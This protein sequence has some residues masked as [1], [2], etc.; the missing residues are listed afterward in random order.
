MVLLWWWGLALAAW[1]QVASKSDSLPGPKR[2]FV[3]DA[4]NNRYLLTTYL[5]G[6]PQGLPVPYSPE[7]YLQYLTT[8]V[9]PIDSL[10]TRLVPDS[11]AHQTQAGGLN[12][13]P[14]HIDLNGY[15]EFAAALHDRRTDN[16]TLNEGD[17]QLRFFNFGQNINLAVS[18]S[19]G[20]RLTFGMNY[21]TDAPFEQDGRRFR[22]AYKGTE[23]EIVQSVELGRVNLMPR[24]SLINPGGGLMGVYGR[25]QL[26]KLRMDVVASRQQTMTKRFTA[27][28]GGQRFASF[29]L[30]SDRY[31]ARRHFFLDHFFRL[32]FD[33][34][35]Q[36]LPAVPGEVYITRVEVWVTNLRG[37]YEGARNMVAVDALGGASD[38]LQPPDNAAGGVY[39]TLSAN[40]ALRDIY[41]VA[42]VMEPAYRLHHTYEAV[43]SARLLGADEYT[44]QPHLGYLMLHRRLEPGDVLAVAYEY[45][46]RGRTYRVGEFSADRPGDT[47]KNLLLRLLKSSSASPADPTWPLMMKNVYAIAEGA[48]LSAN[49]FEL[50]I[51]AR[52]DAK[53]TYLPYFDVPGK[54]EQSILK[55]LG[56]DRLNSLQDPLPDGRYD[57][58]EGYTVNSHLGVVI[59]PWTEPFRRGVEA[60]LGSAAGP[61][62]YP[63]LYDD[64]PVAAA[65]QA[66]QNRYLLRGRYVPTPL[67]SNEASSGTIRQGSVV[68]RAAGVTLTE[69]VDYEVDYATGAVQVINPELKAS[70]VP[71]EVVMEDANSE[72]AQRRSVFGMDLNYALSDTWNV[73]ATWMHLGE[74]PLNPKMAFGY[75]S[76]QNT[77]WGVNLNWRKQST[78]LTE[79]LDAL[80]F[81]RATE[82]SR[83]SLD[84]EFAH[85]IPGH[86]KN[87]YTGDFSYIDDFEAARSYDD[88]LSAYSWSLGSAP[89]H[90]LA[91][92]QDGG[93]AD[94]DKASL[95]THRGLLAWFHIDPILTQPDQRAMPAYLRQQPALL[96]NPYSRAVEAMELFPHRNLSALGLNYL[97]TLNV[98]FYPAERGPYNLNTKEL[99]P[100]GALR[101]PERS[102]GAMMRPLSQ[103]DFEESNIE[104]VEFW[105][106]DPFIDRP[107]D[108]GGVLSIQLGDVSED[109]LSDGRKAFENGLPLNDADETRTAETM[110][111][112]VPTIQPLTFGFDNTSGAL[113]KQDVGLNGLNSEAE[114]RFGTYARYLQ[115]YAQVA[116]QVSKG[117]PEALG[118]PY[119]DPAGDDYVSFM[120]SRYDRLKSPVLDRYKYINGSEGNSSSVWDQPNSYSRAARLLPDVEDINQDNNLNELEQYYD[121]RIDLKPQVL[122]PGNGFVVDSRQAMVKLA[123]GSL[124]PMTWYLFR[125]PIRAYDR[126]VG[127][128]TDFR[129][130][131]FMRIV[132]SQFRTPIQ[133]R[134]GSL[135]LVRGTWR[136]Y[137]LPLDPGRVDT[138]AE[139]SLGTV[140]IEENADRS[141]VNY[142]LPPGVHQP[143]DASGIQLARS[144]EQSLSLSL[145]HLAPAM[146]RGVYKNGQ[147]D[148][149]RYKRI[150]LYAHAE[151]LPADNTEVLDGDLELFVR[152]G[153]DYRQN[154]YEYALPLTLTPEG[155]YD[156]NNPLARERVWPIENLMR[157]PLDRLPQL[158]RQR[159][160]AMARGAASLMQLFVLPDGRSKGHTMGVMGQPSLSDVRALMIGVRNRSGR[161]LSAEVWVDEFRLADYDEDGGWAAR[162]NMGVQLSDVGMANMEVSHFSAGFG[163]LDQRLQERRLGDLTRYDFSTQLDLGRMMPPVLKMSAPLYVS[164]QHQQSTPQYSPLD[165][166]LL[167][168]DALD[169]ARGADR[170]SLLAL[171]QSVQTSTSIALTNVRMDIRSKKPMPYDPANVS[172]SYAHNTAHNRTPDMRFDNSR[173]WR[174]AVNYDYRPEAKPCY[175][176]A[177]WAG[178]DNAQKRA[179][180]RYQLNFW[181]SRIHL[182]SELRRF[183]QEQQMRDVTAYTAPAVTHLQRFFWNR[184]MDV[185]WDLTS[186]LRLEWQSGTEARIAEPYRR[187]NR[188]LDPDGYRIWRDSV[189]AS[190]RRLGEPLNYRQHLLV[191]YTLPTTLVPMLSWIKGDASWQASYNWDR[192]ALMP[193]GESL[194]GNVISNSGVANLRLS[195]DM[196]SC[197]RRW[198]SLDQTLR[199]VEE[200]DDGAMKLHWRDWL[201]YTAMMLRG[202]QLNV[203]EQHSSYIP[204]YAPQV[205][206]AGG[207]LKMPGGA[208][209]PGGRF[210]FGLTG[211]DF[212]ERA[213]DR[214][215]LLA[216][217]AVLSP[218]SLSQ[219]NTF[220]LLLRLRPL[221]ALDLTL[222]F[223]RTDTRRTDIQYALPQRPCNYG[224]FFSMTVVG[225][226]GF[227]AHRTPADGYAS[228][229]F[230]QFLQYRHTVADRWAARY[231]QQAYPNKGFLHGSPLAGSPIP[232]EGMTMSA[233]SAEVL[234]P[235]FRAAYLRGPGAGRIS[236]NP[237]PLFSAMMPNWHI[238]YT[239]LSRLPWVRKYV[240]RLELSTAYRGVYTIGNYSS[241]YGWAALDGESWVG[242]R[243]NEQHEPVPAMPYL[244]PTVSVQ[245]S[246]YPLIGLDVM[247]GGFS[248]GTHWRSSRGLLLNTGAAQL[249]ESF[250][251]EWAL[252][253]SYKLTALP[254]LDL[255]VLLGQPPSQ[256][257]K[258]GGLLLR[259]E[260]S[261]GYT[262][263]LIRN[264]VSTVAQATAGN[265]RNR[266][267]LTA[268]YDLSR[269]LTLRGYYEWN[270]N[271]PLVSSSSFPI[272]ERFYGISLRFNFLGH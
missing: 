55:M 173:D 184:E 243:P 224:G 214:G 62:L 110:W 190:I 10:S 198:T 4:T 61:Y 217:P 140:S 52:N 263:M 38:G 89:L 147:Y 33:K 236:L 226:R 7:Q 146:A 161:V 131:R 191:S 107:Q 37:R 117:T 142:V 240:N 69:H 264:I 168:S 116:T 157:I 259:A 229:P 32:R 22:L 29:E 171:S 93:P 238:S 39:A 126:R 125:V 16:P 122:R 24:N 212:V 169:D 119:N 40:P 187:V 271:K 144:N 216:N 177:A 43:Q 81:V 225:L 23:D 98:S 232:A 21:N 136:I 121:Y 133:L 249:I 193:T 139:L 19:L 36:A 228:A 141:P 44:L 64:T 186:D 76:M 8:G 91:N 71:I 270:S 189:M 3:Y 244:M 88:L 181:P 266:L 257:T 129:S 95:G 48:T 34:A 11:T 57:L 255:G 153:T 103:T 221:P 83:L 82:P 100:N 268:D 170:D 86:Y 256:L 115:D 252:L 132:L 211:A 241:V 200:I 59:L 234:L 194:M 101:Y 73:G 215:W 47:A 192:G 205:G 269:F 165:P 9:L 74:V 118:N 96:S 201:S 160:A 120:D 250:T 60:T 176:L 172:L 137:D 13:G 41:Q 56:M 253:S 227:F 31:D 135:R 185:Q 239:G 149:R 108:G 2:V 54:R 17:C 51:L 145:R 231:L 164:Y 199:R 45:S 72:L 219:T 262:H 1:G 66:E 46:Y 109:V 27:G 138:P 78:R 166:D 242:F 67:A 28:Q 155:Y 230:E 261:H 58:V 204:G 183:Y 182:G 237:L 15:A 223:N 152:L 113:A 104:Y 154:Y 158:K 87:S 258:Q 42:S 128:I 30:T 148:L 202:V 267:R 35:M 94:T 248:L 251:D 196:L 20:E 68:V 213:A 247:S 209:A 99:T 6:R 92:R 254:Q 85:L 235:A 272:R 70:G 90:L 220:D 14:L 233:N 75:E 156:P 53:G 222:T 127:A 208:W 195:M 102:W 130:I 106:L 260:F 5:H 265:L 203:S 206:V 159:N 188:D 18:G 111:G 134:F 179:M 50:Q 245:E 210:A 97:R 12:M 218:A 49:D 84:A 150:E 207:Q 25:L 174:V 175:P 151:Q 143:P 123:D 167:L 124:K 77:L 246:F 105:L 163:A 180:A 112:R 80:P 114:K 162:V 79:W 26:G 197:Y 63:A 178:N 65:A